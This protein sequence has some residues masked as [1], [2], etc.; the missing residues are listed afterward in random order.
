[1]IQ[2][3]DKKKNQKKID[4]EMQT[5]VVEEP[6]SVS[7]FSQNIKPEDSKVADISREITHTQSMKS[8]KS[9]YA[10]QIKL[11]E[12]QETMLKLQESVVTLRI[13]NKTL[14]KEVKENV[15]FQSAPND[16]KMKSGFKMEILTRNES[17]PI[18]EESHNDVEIDSE[19]IDDDSIIDYDHKVEIIESVHYQSS[20]K[21]NSESDNEQEQEE[22]KVQPLSAREP[23]I[24]NK[25]YE[26]DEKG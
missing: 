17:Q 3:H 8:T 19:L 5:D 21:E 2:K 1:L 12:M 22:Q 16:D 26:Q 20:E 23:E 25:N 18:V 6:R 13:E 24:R 15:R 11:R 4:Q 14:K 9:N 7:D 10:D